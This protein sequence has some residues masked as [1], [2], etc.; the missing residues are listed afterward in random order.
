MNSLRNYFNLLV[1]WLLTG[2]WH[3][4]NWTFII[5]GLLYFVFLLIEKASFIGS[6]VEK[7]KALGHIYTLLIVNFLWVI[8]RA[9]GVSQAV[10]YIKTM[11]GGSLCGFYSG[12]TF[13]YIR[14]NIVYLIA[15]IVFSTSILRNVQLKLQAMNE[16]IKVI[17]SVISE[18]VLII[19]FIV[20]IVYVINGTYNPFIYF[21]F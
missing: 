16:G 20:S 14:E 12:K 5:W 8:F 15:A 21:N 7:H 13:V 17:M 9:D 4:A 11:L 10:Q 6:F 2:V 1:V 18:I 3:G 19:V